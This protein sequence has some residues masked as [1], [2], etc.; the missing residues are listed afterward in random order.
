MNDCLKCKYCIEDYVFDEDTGEE[1]PLYDCQKGKDTSN[2]FECE[3]FEEYKPKKYVEKDTECDK[4]EYLSECI[5]NE[6]IYCTT[7]QDKRSHVLCDMTRC[8]KK[9]VVL[10]WKI[11][12]I[13]KTW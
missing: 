13:G 12:I 4:C 9:G 8:K 3:Y 2:D 11:M 10:G 6:H 5:H 1:Y 7:F